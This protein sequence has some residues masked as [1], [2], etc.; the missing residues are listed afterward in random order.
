MPPMPI[1]RWLLGQALALF[2]KHC[3][4]WG[5]GG[6][7]KSGALGTP[8]AEGQQEPFLGHSRS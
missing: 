2:W 1:Q 3:S 6:P 4:T 7:E 5:S 8:K